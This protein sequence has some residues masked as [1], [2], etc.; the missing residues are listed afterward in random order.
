MIIIRPLIKVLS[1]IMELPKGSFLDP[2]TLGS[3]NPDDTNFLRGDGTWNTPTLAGYVPDSRT[4]TIDGVS[5]DL[6]ADRTW[7]VIP[8]GGTTGQI[9]AKLDDTSYNLEWIE[10][11]A[12]YT[13]TLKHEVK[14]GEAMTKGQAVYVSSA[15]GTNMIVSKASNAT[16]ATSSKTMGLIA[17]TLA[18]NGKG[19]VIT[20]GLLAGLNTASATAGDPVWLGT[21]G[22][23]IYG[24]INKPAAPAHLVFI[25]I[26]TR[27]NVSNGEIFVRVQNGFELQEL[28]NVSITSVADNDLLQYNSATSLW[29]NE[30]LS[31]AGIQP[32]LTSGTNIKTINSTTL[33]GSGDL[34]VQPTLV[35]A[36]NIKTINGTTLLGSGDLT[37]GSA[38]GIFGISNASG[39]YTYYA[40]FTLAMAAATSGQTIEM[41]ADVTETGA[42]TVTLK[43]GVNING[44]GHTYTLNNSGLSHSFSAANS[45]TTSC[46]ILNLNVI[47]TGSTG[48]L[49]DNS[50]LILGINGTGIINCSGSTFRNSGSG[51]GMLFN[52]SST[53]Q[54]NYAIAYATTTW[55]AFGIFS[56]AG[57]K[58]NNSIGYGTSGGYG[59]RCHNGGDIDKCTGSSDSGYGIYGP[60]GNHS[61]CMGISVS[62]IGFNSGSVSIT[63]IGRSTS[64]TGLEASGASSIV[65]CV[66]I[67]TSGT[68]ISSNLS[69]LYNCTGISSSSRGVQLISNSSKAYNLISKSTSSYSVLSNSSAVEIHNSTIISEWNNVGGIGISSNNTTIPGII[70][71]STFILS[72]A[73]APYLFNNTAAQAVS[74][75]GNTYR[76]GGAYS[77]LIT[78]AI[79]AVEDAQGNI[80]L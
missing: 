62:G 19:F 41:F 71:N 9:L 15:D 61:N 1:K 6:S 65:N 45:V 54:I 70:L 55:G 3:G 73:S 47:R 5:Q 17:Q 27:A 30:S 24:L 60:T 59:I 33:L 56:S 34:A 46:N 20:E 11:F 14:A 21:G 76:G 66:G 77:V 38:S 36:T 78:Q 80:F 18:H 52:T 13:S 4:I 57:A 29:N 10:N 63:C 35:S 79:A 53:H 31:T 51:C 12:N 50:C 75:R 68:G 28:H 16:E 7:D 39:V 44:N 25:G 67:S 58:L 74:T 48:T 2:T 64:G 22:N 26:V 40:T 49:F 8:S 23:L 42:V 72:N 43:N 32:T 69:F 37:V